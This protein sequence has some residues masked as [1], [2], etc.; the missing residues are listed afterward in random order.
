MEH[1][2]RERKAHATRDNLNSIME[3]DHVI[4]VHEDGTVSDGPSSL[5]APTLMDEELD[6]AGWLLLDGYTQQHGYRGPIMGDGEYIGGRMADYILA[7]PGI[8]VAIVAF[9]L[10]EGDDDGD[11]VMEGWAVARRCDHDWLAGMMRVHPEDIEAVAATGRRVECMHCEITY[12]HR[13]V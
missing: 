13:I 9:W 8:Y 5:Y 11:T 10:P 4:T 7:T 6:G 12:R 3:F 1:E 2:R